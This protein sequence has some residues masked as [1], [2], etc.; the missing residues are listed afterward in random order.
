MR[1]ANSWT[2]TLLGISPSGLIPSAR[3]SVLLRRYIML[4]KILE[5]LS[6]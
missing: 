3:S 2:C 4:A 6:R 5:L 1:T